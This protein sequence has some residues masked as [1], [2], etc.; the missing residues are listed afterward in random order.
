MDFGTLLS[1]CVDEFT[2]LFSFTNFAD[3]YVV[4]LALGFGFLVLLSSLLRFEK[5]VRTMFTVSDSRYLGLIQNASLRRFKVFIL[6]I[7]CYVISL[8]IAYGDGGGAFCIAIA[9]FL[10]IVALG[11][12][13]AS[14]RVRLGFFRV[15]FFVAVGFGIVFYALALFGVV[16]DVDLWDSWKTWLAFAVFLGL[17]SELFGLR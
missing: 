13:S 11:I 17:S 1:A 5:P 8:L 2:F 4:C 10:A 12:R 9:V 16:Q 14:V 15:L 7:V 3:A 6:G